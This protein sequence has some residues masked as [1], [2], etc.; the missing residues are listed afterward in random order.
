MHIGV[1]AT[2][3]E[4]CTNLGNVA[5]SVEESLERDGHRATNSG[6][7]RTQCDGH[8]TVSQKQTSGQLYGSG[9]IVVIAVGHRCAMEEH[10]EQSVGS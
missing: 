4:Q 7:S 3:S 1:Q 10:H 8:N 5:I 9:H 6:V 2:P